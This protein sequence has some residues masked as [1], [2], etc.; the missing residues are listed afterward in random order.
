LTHA[1]QIDGM[2]PPSIGTGTAGGGPASCGG[3][4][5]L[6]R[7]LPNPVALTRVLAAERG[8]RS[9]APPCERRGGG[10]GRCKN[11]AVQQYMLWSWPQNQR[12]SLV[13]AVGR[14]LWMLPSS[15]RTAGGP[16]A[17]SLGQ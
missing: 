10:R 5:G 15:G 4:L 13:L 11:I 9:L 2:H 14:V 8:A 16:P 17:A 6:L 3:L 7:L 1:Q 12:C